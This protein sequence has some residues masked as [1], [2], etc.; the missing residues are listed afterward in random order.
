M[1]AIAVAAVAAALLV[2]SVVA[3]RGVEERAR[4]RVER[5]LGEEVAVA[6]E[7]V[8]LVAFAHGGEIDGAPLRE[9]VDRIAVATPGLRV[10]II[11]SDGWVLVDSHEDREM[12][13]NH[14]GRPELTDPGVVFERYSRTLRRSM[15]YCAE[16]VPIEPLSADGGMRGVGDFVHVRLALASEDVA[17]QV[18][19]EIETAKGGAWRGL[20]VGLLI[21]GV[22]AAWVTRPARA[23]AVAVARQDD[24]PLEIEGDDEV[25]FVAATLGARVNDQIGR[26]ERLEDALDRDR[27]I[28]ASMEEGVVILDREGRIRL[29]N[30]AA[31]RLLRMGSGD[32]NGKPL[33]D[34]TKS[35]EVVVAVSQSLDTDTRTLKEVRLS[36]T[37]M[38]EAVIHL[39]AVPL[40]EPGSPS[41]GCVVVL[42]DLTEIRRLEAMRRDFVAN[43]SHELKTPLTAMKGYLE[44]VIDDDEMESEQRRRFLGKARNNTDRLS[45]IVSDLLALARMQ[46]EDGVDL[47]LVDLVSIVDTC[48]RD[49]RSS[50]ELRDVTIETR[51]EPGSYEMVGDEAA[52][53]TAVRNL[54]DN[55]LKYSPEHSEVVAALRLDGD[56]FVIDVSDEGPGIPLHEQE[57]IFERFYRV[58][59]NRSRELGGTGLGLSI[60]KNAVLAHQG[61]V[62]VSSRVGRGSTFSIRL[63]REN[64]LREAGQGS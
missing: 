26:I 6:S 33:V 9:F 54:V 63:P 40:G 34:V 38:G 2:T 43:V 35:H 56:D 42:Y 18:D 10:T 27:A 36:G 3:E 52:L 30:E 16:T 60:V 48:V 22:G 13:D 58:D 21:A 7:A 8:R 46:G 14:G 20:L 11:D 17:D 55:A 37:A 19:A 29:V 32:M 31:R 23:A 1:L 39:S 5:Q 61:D 25:S 28:F 47:E 51:V 59:K 4:A 12:M 62:S 49:L 44:A 45:A 53:V 50:A 41:W 15:L 64:R 57:R 24:E